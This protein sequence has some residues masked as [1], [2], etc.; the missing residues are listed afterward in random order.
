MAS[1][2]PRHFRD[3]NTSFTGAFCLVGL[4]RMSRCSAESVS[5]DTCK[6]PAACPYTHCHLFT[7][8]PHA[9]QRFSILYACLHPT[10]FSWRARPTRY[11]CTP[12]TSCLPCSPAAIVSTFGM[13]HY[14]LQKLATP[15]GGYVA[16]VCCST[17]SQSGSGDLRLR[18]PPCWSDSRMTQMQDF[19]IPFQGECNEIQYRHN[20]LY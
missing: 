20:A 2:Y 15:G 6:I 13:M 3:Q 17:G 4:P 19:H 14:S 16:G 5:G 1:C 11:V 10:I 9:T 8:I 7:P 12:E 18:L